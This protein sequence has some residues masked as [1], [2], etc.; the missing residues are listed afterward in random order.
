MS[1][2]HTPLV[3]AEFRSANER[4]TMALTGDSIITRKLSV[5]D[6]P[7]YLEMIELIRDADVAFTNLEVLFHDYESYPMATSGGTYM[8]ADPELASELAWAGF[9]LLARA[10]NHTGD[11]GVEGMRIT[12]RHVRDAGLLGAGVGE[13]LAEAR[14]AKFLETSKARVALISLA[15]S[16][17]KHMGA[18]PSRD[19][20]PARPGL[21]PLRYDTTYEVEAA[22]FERLK[23]LGASL[24]QFRN[25]DGEPRGLK[26]DKPDE[27]TLFGRDFR[28]AESNR[29]RTTPNER[30]M[31]AIA[32]V[33][34]N[35]SRVADFV[36][37]TIHAHEGQKRSEPAEFLPVFARR[38]I[39]AGADVFVGHGPHALRG[40]EIYEGKPIL[41]S[42]GDFIFQNETL[43]RLPY[44][45]YAR[46][47]LDESSHLADFND[48]R[49]KNDS[50]GFPANPEIWEAVVAVPVFENR[51]LVELALHP[52]TL[53]YGLPRQVRGRPMLADDELGAKIINDLRERS[54]PFGTRITEQRGVG[55]VELGAGN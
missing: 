1:F 11:Y 50:S 18:G 8:R 10:N 26:A 37:V 52:I 34:N 15:S 24:G 7:E 3:L 32:A 42:L 4:F 22:D 47:D 48:A 9:D 44:D 40:I 54:A 19:D 17:A 39:D 14:E 28:L 6:E 31:D 5:Y 43:L 13:S 35:A 51:E 45:N 49:Y 38:M 29:V 27:M 12:T 16:F 20:I 23:A 55:Y 2:L 21:N 53:G 30:D 36:I 25:Q 46:Y 41:Y 33:V